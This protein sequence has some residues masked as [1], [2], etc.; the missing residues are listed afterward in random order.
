MQQCPIVMVSLCGEKIT[1]CSQIGLKTAAEGAQISAMVQFVVKHSE[2]PMIWLWG[3]ILCSDSYTA[4]VKY[5][6]LSL[7]SLATYDSS[8]FSRNQSDP[9]DYGQ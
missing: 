6:Q 1:E 5:L 3:E 2:Q 4:N 9:A 7:S 8:A